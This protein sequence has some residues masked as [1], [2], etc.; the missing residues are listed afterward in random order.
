MFLWFLATLT[1]LNFTLTADA[2][3]TLDTIVVTASA[4]DLI[5]TA[6][7]P[8]AS[9]GLETLENAPTI[10]RNI[11]DVLRIDPRIYVDE[12]RGDINPVQCGGKNPRFQLSDLRRRSLE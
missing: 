9:F 5:Q 1:N 11:T 8:N 7:G 4:T 2:D 10:N 6:V 12:S 3:R